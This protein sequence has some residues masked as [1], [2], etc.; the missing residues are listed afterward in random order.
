MV[1][2]EPI[3]LPEGARRVEVEVTLAGMPHPTLLVR[4][5]GGWRVELKGGEGGPGSGA[6]VETQPA[7]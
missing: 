6:A 7:G 3:Q 5:E 1:E 4:E 2:V